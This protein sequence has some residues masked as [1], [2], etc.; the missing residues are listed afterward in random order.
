MKKTIL[1]LLSTL[2]VFSLTACQKAAEPSAVPD[3]DTIVQEA[4]GYFEQMRSGDFETIYNA[5]PD[6]VKKQTKSAQTIQDS[7]NEAAEKAGGLL[8]NSEPKVSCY[9]P[10]HAEQIR[11]EFVI[12]CENEDF[13]IFINYDSSE[14]LYNYVVWKN[15]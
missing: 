2:M 11:V 10:E 6:G 5:L 3:E 9:N 14:N 12:P 15:S 7:W 13:K 8:E 1:I 4:T